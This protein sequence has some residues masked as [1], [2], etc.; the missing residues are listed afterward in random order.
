MAT[1]TPPKYE[2]SSRP[3]AQIVELRQ[4]RSSLFWVFPD[5]LPASSLFSRPRDSS[6]EAFPN[7]PMTR[8]RVAEVF[9]PLSDHGLPLCWC[10][11]LWHFCPPLFARLFAYD[12]RT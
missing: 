11:C 3:L 7:F 4:W 9:Q 5:E 12:V 2:P 8:P 6:G 1:E 10:N